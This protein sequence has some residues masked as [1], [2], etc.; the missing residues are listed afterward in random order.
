MW[1]TSLFCFTSTVDLQRTPE[2]RITEKIITVCYIFMKVFSPV[3][4]PVQWYIRCMSQRQAV[5]SSDGASCNIQSVI[6]SWQVHITV[7]TLHITLHIAHGRATISQSSHY[8]LHITHGRSISQSSH[9]TLHITH[10]RATI[11][12]SSCSPNK[13]CEVE[14]IYFISVLVHSLWDH[15]IMRKKELNGR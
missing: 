10:G 14:R 4:F 3:C 1:D 9:Y 6:H 2:W 5:T 13:Q 15:N 8:T 11:S 12:Q 7:I